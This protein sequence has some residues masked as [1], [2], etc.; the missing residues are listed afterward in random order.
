ML[1]LST[2]EAGRYRIWIGRAVALGLTVLLL[3]SMSLP[4]AALAGGELPARGFEFFFL[5]LLDIY[6][7]LAS[8][9]SLISGQNLFSGRLPFEL[10]NL[11]PFA[12]AMAAYI[13]VLVIAGR[14]VRR[15]W[16][17][18]MV[19]AL[20][21]TFHATFAPDNYYYSEFLVGGY[22]FA[23]TTIAVAILG[24]AYR[25]GAPSEH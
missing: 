21:T 23:L 25:A 22:L 2:I 13:C 15:V 7:L 10:M 20:I 18:A 17:L 24:F 1:Q 5:C 9:V 4:F 19:A 6:L 11:S 8:I 3:V 12:W 16:T 14:P